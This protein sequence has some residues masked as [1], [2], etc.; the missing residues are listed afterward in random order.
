MGNL[1]SN[2]GNNYSGLK[3]IKYSEIINFNLLLWKVE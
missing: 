2:K 3:L 1:N